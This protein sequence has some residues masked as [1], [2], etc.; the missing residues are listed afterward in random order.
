MI[1][2]FE[3]ISEEPPSSKKLS[4]IPTFSIPSA[5][6]NIAQSSVWTEVTGATYPV[7]SVFTSG[8]GSA[9]LS[10]LPPGVTGS[11]SR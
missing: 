10:I 6:S 11:L 9:F 5:F 7:L 1:A 3:A 2:T 8:N 4:S